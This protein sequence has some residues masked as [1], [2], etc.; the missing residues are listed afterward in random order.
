[1]WTSEPGVTWDWA[2]FGYNVTNNNGAPNGFGRINGAHGQAYMRFDTGGNLYFYNTNTGGTRYTNMELYSNN[3]VYF[4]NYATGG[5]S[6][7]APIFYDSNNTGYFADPAG[8]SRLSSMDYGDGG[9]YLAGG[10]WGYRHNTPYGYIEFGPANTSHAHIYTDR[11]NFYFNVNEMY[12]NGRF[13]LNENL[14]INNK[15]FGSDGAIYGTIFYDSN[16][17]AYYYDGASDNST[18]MRG[19]S[20]ETM[21]HMALSGQTRSS[22]QYYQARARITSD[23]NYWIGSMGWG[24]VDMNTVADWGSG[25]IDS[26]SNPGNQPAGTSHWVGTQAYHYSNGSARY[27]WQMVGGPI[28]GLWFR[29][30]WGSF[31]GWR[32]IV[33]YGLNEYSTDL[34][35]SILYDSN[36]SGYYC[37]PNGTN[38][39]NNVDTNSIYSRDWFRNNNSGQGLYNQSTGMHIYS[40]NGYIKHAGGG[41]GYGGVAHYNNY[42]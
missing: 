5:N 29:N 35:A 32:K 1:M 28:A 24:T 41:Y 4:N 22:T 23:Q 21:A 16:N 25:F 18:R 8:R 27:G 17:S 15:Y 9:Y 10:S 3:T 14:W 2:G 11:G 39:F 12:M 38:R 20:N 30:T 40:N 26:W 37:D 31:S 42:E 33:M 19:V 6:L 34:W 36:D 13:V 7:R